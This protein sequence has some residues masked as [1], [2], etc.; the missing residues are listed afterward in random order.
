VPSIRDLV[1][2]L[3]QREGVDAVVVLGRDGLVIDAQAAPDV[4]PEGLAAR[5]PS[6]VAAGEE[7]GA[8]Q[9]AGALVT[10]VLEYERGAA[11]ACVLSAEAILVVLA[12]ADAD[13]G[14][15]L[16]ELRRNRGRIAAIV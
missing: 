2:A 11:I 13:L 4:D 16:F 9:S 10:T 12:S 8:Q 15:L 7:L 3:R 14:S 5:V 1:R 6:V